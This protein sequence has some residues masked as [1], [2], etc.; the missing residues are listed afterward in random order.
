MYLENAERKAMKEEIKR[1]VNAIHRQKDTTPKEDW[2]RLNKKINETV[3][4]WNKDHPKMP[5]YLDL[6]WM[7]VYGALCF[8]E[9][10]LLGEP[11]TLHVE[12]GV[13]KNSKLSMPQIKMSILKTRWRGSCQEGYCTH[14]VPA[15]DMNGVNDKGFENI[16]ACYKCLT[17]PK[18]YC[19]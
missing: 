10:E 1:E 9:K 6:H 11:E 17:V 15:K 14:Q 8:V 12:T 19:I 13:G 4:R 16:Q 7:T 2:H 18:S 5:N 3:V